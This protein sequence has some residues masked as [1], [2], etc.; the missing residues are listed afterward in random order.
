MTNQITD[1]S[2]SYIAIAGLVVSIL[3]HFGVVVASNDVVGI[4]AAL[5]T[6]YGIGAQMVA[7][8]K[9][10]ASVSTQ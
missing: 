5:A 7:H 9:L 4:I 6:I 2:G 1:Y 8:K 10:A 3:G